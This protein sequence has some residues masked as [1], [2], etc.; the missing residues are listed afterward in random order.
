MG[1]KCVSVSEVENLAM[2]EQLAAN[3]GV[4]VAIRGKVVLMKNVEKLETSSGLLTKRDC[5]LS[6]ESKACKLVLWEELVNVVETGKCYSISNVSVRTYSG[7]KYFSS[8]KESEVQEIAEIVGALDEGHVIDNEDF[9]GDIIGVISCNSF[10]CCLSCAAKVEEIGVASGIGCCVKCGVKQKLARCKS[11]AVAKVILENEEKI[12]T[13]TI[14]ADVMN[15]LT[16]H[17]ESG[18]YSREPDLEMK[19]LG[20]TRKKFKIKCKNVVYRVDDIQPE[21]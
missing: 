1:E 3:A 5:V 18:E 6:D 8:S 10:R 14:F 4:K 21:I 11:N 7:E 9:V 20:V 17:S 13:V 2:I 12:R 19:L 15:E 16:S